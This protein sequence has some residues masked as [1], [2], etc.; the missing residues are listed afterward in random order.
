MKGMIIR[1]DKSALQALV[2]GTIIRNDKS[3][4]QALEHGMSEDY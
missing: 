2:Q 4:L 1:N 3:A